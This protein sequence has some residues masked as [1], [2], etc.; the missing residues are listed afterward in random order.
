MTKSLLKKVWKQVQTEASQTLNRPGKNLAEKSI[1]VHSSVFCWCHDGIK[2]EW[3]QE[4]NE[5]Q[6]VKVRSFSS[7]MGHVT[8]TGIDQGPLI[9]SFSRLSAGV[10]SLFKVQ[11]WTKSSPLTS[12]K[13][14]TKK[15]SE[16]MNVETC[17]CCSILSSAVLKTL[18]GAYCKA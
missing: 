8:I 9:F 16:L 12:A 14:R 2:T 3:Q 7:N 15:I 11:P 18:C 6:K 5:P 10:T 17:S 1:E 4:V 13:E